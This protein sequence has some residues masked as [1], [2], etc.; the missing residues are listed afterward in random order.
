MTISS[1][2]VLDSAL[3]SWI[4]YVILA[5]AA[6]KLAAWQHRRNLALR[7]GAQRITNY[8]SDHCFGFRNW[9]ILLHHKRAGTFTEYGRLEFERVNNPKV[10][11]FIFRIF[12]VEIISTRDP[13][14]IKAILATQ[15]LDFTLGLRHPQFLPLL[16]SGIFTL[17]GEGWKH[18]R[19]LLRPQFSR[20]QIAHVRALEPHLQLLVNHIKTHQ[21]KEFDIQELFYRFTLDF[22]TEFLFGESTSSLADEAIG[23]VEGFDNFPEQKG[24]AEAFNYVQQVLSS[25]AVFLEFYFLMDGPKF[26]RCI[27]KVHAFAEHYVTW[28][29]STSHEELKRRSQGGYV[30][31][32]ELA[33]ETLDPVVLRDQLLNILVAGR[34]TTAGL[35]SFAMYELARNPK[36]W[37]TLR[38]EVSD[39]FGC[40]PEARIQDITF[41]ALKQSPYLKAVLNETLRMYPAVPNNFRTAARETTLPRG[42]GKDGLS[43]IL[44][45]K[46]QI[47]AYTI[48]STQ[49]DPAIYGEDAMEFKPERWS[50]ERT[51]RLGWSFLPFNGGPRIC[52]GQQFALTEA[53]YVL[54][55][56]AQVFSHLGGDNTD[57]P[58]PP[59]MNSHLTLSLKDGALVCMK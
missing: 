24:F 52:L 10:P 18:S 26:R 6:L 46:G 4:L 34:D 54:V 19:A 38:D 57:K 25:R 5:V 28:A 49:R 30:F 47:V 51:R 45:R 55:R 33:M 53:S 7:L 29:L 1:N 21:D 41:E 17:D 3:R 27:S 35:L 44:I 48:Y 50:E 31:L 13:E 20:D 39:R 36:L 32:Y 37:E 22:S 42:G 15:F 59:R 58:Y 8:Q 43:P 56:L 9:Y 12:G 23:F 16:G 11:T 14:N 2:S 40:G